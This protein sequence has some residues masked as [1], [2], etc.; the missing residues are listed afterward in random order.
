M[1]QRVLIVED[2]IIVADDLEWKLTSLGYETI[3]IAVS[4]EEALD[5]VKREHPDVVLMDIQLQGK[6]NG[7]EAAKWIQQETG[8]ATIFVTAY[9]ATLVRGPDQMQPPGVCVSKPFSTVQLKAAMDSVFIALQ[10]NKA[11][12]GSRGNPA[13]QQHTNGRPK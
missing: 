10:S 7:I 13:V 6:I 1:K 12:G 11:P 2:E 3:G 8:A 9:P 4:G 5:L